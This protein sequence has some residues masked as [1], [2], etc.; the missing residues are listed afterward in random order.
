M[1]DLARLTA[2]HA[3]ATSNGPRTVTA[4]CE[5]ADARLTFCEIV[6]RDWGKIAAVLEAARRFLPGDVIQKERREMELEAA[7]AALEDVN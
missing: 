1:T 2:L 4:Y 6:V 7:L 3:L 5:R